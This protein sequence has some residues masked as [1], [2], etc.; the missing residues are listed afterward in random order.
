MKSSIADLLAIAKKALTNVSTTPTLDADLLLSALLNKPRSY[1]Y[2]HHNEKIAATKTK[3]F[4]QFIH[5]RHSGEAVAYIIGKKEFWSLQFIVNKNTLIPRPETELLVEIILQQF[6]NAAKITL[7]DLGTGCGAIALALA[8]ERPYWH[9]I[10]TDKSEQAL[11]IAQQNA[12]QFNLNNV[13]FRCGNWCAV[14]EDN[15]FDVIVSNPPY[16]DSADE[17]LQGD[18]AHEP[19]TAL[20]A[21]DSGLADLHEIIKNASNK[22]KPNGLLLLEHGY[23]QSQKVCDLLHK[24]GYHQVKSYKDLAGHCRATQGLRS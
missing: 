10:A 4:M 8:Q 1:L 12:Q 24:Y 7:A 23:Q 9:I 5:R 11:Q 22:L 19:A 3:L 17:Y 13:E 18:I 21:A 20:I 2:A 6:A 14:L 16:I 15:A